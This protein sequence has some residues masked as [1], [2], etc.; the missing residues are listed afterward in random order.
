[1][2]RRGLADRSQQIARAVRVLAL[3]PGSHCRGRRR[4]GRLGIERHAR[5]A[6]R[7]ALPAENERVVPALPSQKHGVDETLHL[8]GLFSR[9]P[10][11]SVLGSPPGSENGGI[12]PSAPLD[13][14]RQRTSTIYPITLDTYHTVGANEAK[15]RVTLVRPLMRIDPVLLLR[16]SARPALPK[17]I[18]KCTSAAWLLVV[19]AFSSLS[20]M[21]GLEKLRV[22]DDVCGGQ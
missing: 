15:R 22:P 3:L 12:R 20:L 7:D 21:V 8:G 10:D 19:N 2:L 17:I 9:P 1:M 11:S 5:H 18:K 13:H 16:C 6:A 14:W 4:S